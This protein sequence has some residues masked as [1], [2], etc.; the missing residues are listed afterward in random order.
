MSLA[1]KYRPQS[2]KDVVGHDEIVTAMVNFKKTMDIPNLLFIGAPGTGKTTLA[3][4]FIKYLF[5]EDYKNN[6]LELNASDENSVDIVRT[7]VKDFAIR[8]SIN[9]N[10]PRIIFLDEVDK[11]TSAAQEAL[12]KPMEAF[13]S[14]SRFILCSNS[15][16]IHAALRSRCICF[17]FKPLCSEDIE[18]R[19]M[20]VIGQEKISITKQEIQKIIKNSNGDLRQAL[21]LLHATVSGVVLEEKLENYTLY[22]M[23]IKDFEDKILY[24]Y[25]PRTILQK[26]FDETLINKNY[27]LIPAL[28]AADFRLSGQTI[29]TLQILDAFMQ[30]KGE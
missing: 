15:D 5:R 8:K 29:K 21:N 10:F 3:Q 11:L 16:N 4:L 28:A 13:S 22:N 12:K 6:F 1:E 14:T 2:L 19:V 24:K 18:N 25:E 30:M 9:S 26:L 20:Q 23:S 7:K 27:K 17:N